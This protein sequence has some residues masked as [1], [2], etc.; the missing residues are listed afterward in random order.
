MYLDISNNTIKKIEGVKKT[1]RYTIRGFA[2]TL[3]CT[4]SKTNLYF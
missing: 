1:S 3:V 4:G 2:L